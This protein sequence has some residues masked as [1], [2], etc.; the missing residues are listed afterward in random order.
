MSTDTT[1]M[2]NRDGDLLTAVNEVVTIDQATG[3]ELD[4]YPAAGPEEAS[5]A[6]QAAA[7]RRANAGH[8]RVE[9]RPFR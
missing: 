9:S 8:R 7:A 6:V 5:A 4:R 2:T 1:G 3:S